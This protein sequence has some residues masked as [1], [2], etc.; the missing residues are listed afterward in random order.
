MDIIKDVQESTSLNVHV[1]I[2]LIH[3]SVCSKTD[4]AGIYYLGRD[5]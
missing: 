5:T 3:I 4:L 2:E 1:C